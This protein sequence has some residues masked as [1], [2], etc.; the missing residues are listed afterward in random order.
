M[1]V[2]E[3]Y[4]SDHY[5]SDAR[6]LQLM[7]ALIMLW[8]SFDSDPPNDTAIK[9]GHFTHIQHLLLCEN[10]LSKQVIKLVGADP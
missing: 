8:S 4:L 3:L 1:W 5:K 10:L 6:I 7:D 2:I 9:Y